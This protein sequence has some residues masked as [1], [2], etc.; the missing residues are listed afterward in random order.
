M[1]ATL[2]E[3]KCYFCQMLQDLVVPVLGRKT[4][5]FPQHS[6][7]DRKKEKEKEE[8]K[9]NRWGWGAAVSATRGKLGGSGI[10]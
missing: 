3:H 9:V 2:K 10:G 7:N 4:A 6:L 5:S 1:T 8:M